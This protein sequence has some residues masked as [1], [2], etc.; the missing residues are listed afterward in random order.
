MNLAMLKNALN[1]YRKNGGGARPQA[2]NGDWGPGGGAGGGGETV[3]GLL[4]AERM[5]GAGQEQAQPDF[6]EDRP[7]NALAAYREPQ[8]F[9]Q[10][11]PERMPQRRTNV[12]RSMR[13]Y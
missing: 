11:M 2:Y 6:F 1:F 9:D 12:L 13:G 3:P 4:W 7:F 10:Q 8:G 5:A